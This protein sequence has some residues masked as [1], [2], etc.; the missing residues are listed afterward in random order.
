MLR[1]TINCVYIQRAFFYFSD[2]RQPKQEKQTPCTG[3]FSPKQSGRKGAILPMPVL[4][5]KYYQT[6][7]NKSL[8]G[9]H[10]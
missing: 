8:W 3:E 7:E 2:S 9:I 5:V 10:K 4:T 6:S 1:N